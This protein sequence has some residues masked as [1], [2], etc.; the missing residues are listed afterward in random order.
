MRSERGRIRI[1][2]IPYEAEASACRT[3]G[4]IAPRRVEGC[5]VELRV[6]PDGATAELDGRRQQSMHPAGVQL[7]PGDHFYLHALA[8]EL[9]AAIVKDL[10]PVSSLRSPLLGGPGDGA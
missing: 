6:R 8:P 1:F 10:G 3:W 7:W 9:V 2:Y 5:A 4:Q